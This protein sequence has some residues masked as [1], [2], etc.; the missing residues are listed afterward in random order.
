MQRCEGHLEF[1]LDACCAEHPHICGGCDGI[2]KQCRF[3][4]PGRAA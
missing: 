4:H 1:G 2:V 3:A